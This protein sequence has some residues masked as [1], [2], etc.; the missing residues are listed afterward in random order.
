MRINK[1]F[2]DRGYCSRREADRL[3]EAGRVRIND[4]KAVLGDQ[5][6]ENDVVMI[7]GKQLAAK[8]DAIYIMYNKPF[9]VTCTVDIG[10]YTTKPCKLQALGENKFAI[11]LT[12]GKNR[13]IR[14]MTDALGYKVKRLHRIRIMNIEIGTLASGEWKDIPEQKLTELK[15]L[16]V[17]DIKTTTENI[18]VEE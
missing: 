2:T 6:G 13:Q 4:R 12:E 17:H 1:Y 14:R 8:Q 7:D 3:I 10:G 15:N 18:D 5:V 16:L 11:I 9:G